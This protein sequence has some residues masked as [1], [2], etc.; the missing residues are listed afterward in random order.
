[1]N[2]KEI[3]LL[4]IFETTDGMVAVHIPLWISTI[5]ETSLE[6]CLESLIDIFGGNKSK[7]YFYKFDD[8]WFM[9]HELGKWHE[10]N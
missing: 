5:I 1:M 8:L 2:Q 4:K 9:A 6:D 3:F 7:I 10:Q